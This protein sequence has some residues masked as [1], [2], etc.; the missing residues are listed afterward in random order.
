MLWSWLQ[1]VA[2]S[3]ETA[4]KT[5]DAA[6]PPPADPAQQAT[7]NTTKKAIATQAL[8]QAH[9]GLTQAQGDQAIEDAL[10]R[11]KADAARAAKASSSTSSGGPS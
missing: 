5:A 1:R 6:V 11:L 9:P 2:Q 4:V 8:H 3:A 7:A 10:K